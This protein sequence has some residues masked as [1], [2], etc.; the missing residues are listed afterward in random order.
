MSLLEEACRRLDAGDP[1]SARRLAER[2]LEAGRTSGSRRATAAAAHLV[3]EC[4]YV[5]GDIAGS[6]RLADEALALSEELADP[7]ALG[8]DLN[9]LG[10]LE[11]TE[12]R[13]E[14]AIDLLRRSLELRGQSLGPDDPETIESLNNLAVALWRA[15]AQDEAIALHEDALERCERALGEDHRRTAETLNALAVKLEARPE[16]RARA[17]ELYERALAS[18]DA[19]LG[20][21]ADLVARLLANVANARMEAGDL[22]SAGPL[23]E[24]SVKLHEKHFGVSNRWT[25]YAL[26]MQASHAEEVGR[27]DVARRAFERAF[28]IRVQELG[29]DEPETIEATMGLMGV[30]AQ[31]GSEEA[32]NLAT[33][34][35]LP[36]VAFDP[37]LGASA[38]GMTPDPER[39]AEQLRQIADR[40]ARQVAPEEGTLEALARAGELTEQADTA[41][42]VGD[43]ASAARLLREALALLETELGPNDIA[44]VEPLERLRRVLRFAGTESE[45]LPIL[46]RIAEIYAAAYGDIHPLAIRALAEV[47]WQEQRE[48]GPAGGAETAARI[49]QLSRDAIGDESDLGRLLQSVFDVAR[50]RVPEG[51][52]PE[53]PPLSV[54]RER[55]LAE[56]DPLADELLP[57]L[58]TVPWASL[59]HAYGPAI[60]TPLHLRLLL[61]RDERVRTDAHDLLAD[62]LLH[63]GSTYPATAPALT[64]IRRLA[65][66]ERVPGR[67][68]LLGF[69]EAAD[70]LE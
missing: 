51:A 27:L 38:P 15:G 56:P 11:L 2:A 46:R 59:E 5:Q 21:D 28:V 43:L 23:H 62:S 13:N 6:R 40:L 41:Y 16:T 53:D 29:P 50:A 32:R 52:T 64:F 30:L 9:L 18:A 67:D 57:D 10:V 31:D 63:Q 69:V 68:D 19:A 36:L 66:D 20:P 70:S 17:H 42:L 58:D 55:I 33:A 44:L 54:R 12:G 14:E 37:E 26:V 65:A 39:A 47:Y 35:Y 60:D 61:A 49:A 25:A 48:Y 7:A 24:R 3:G 1:G 45:V 4:L 8:A 22:E 34:L